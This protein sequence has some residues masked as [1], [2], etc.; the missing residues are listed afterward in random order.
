ME[1]PR[2]RPGLLTEV[3]ELHLDD[4]GYAVGEVSR[5]L[6]LNL[7]EFVRLHL[8]GLSKLLVL[9]APAGEAAPTRGNRP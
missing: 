2:E 4:L 8:Q 1:V 6:H 3:V 5:M 7:A 9:P